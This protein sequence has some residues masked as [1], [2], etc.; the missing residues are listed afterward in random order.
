MYRA[1][2][3][4]LLPP[5]PALK[6]ENAAHRIG[7]IQDH[8]DIPALLAGQAIEGRTKIGEH[9]YFES[10]MCD[11]QAGSGGL[12]A[13]SENAIVVCPFPPRILECLRTRE[14]PTVARAAR[15][16]KTF[17]VAT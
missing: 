2:E 12:S 9:D 13:A 10:P 8:M 4:V 5:K 16:N 15:A 6:S 11:I 14:Y 1:W 3:N 17:L 7:R